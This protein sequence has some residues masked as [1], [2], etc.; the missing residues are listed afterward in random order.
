MYIMVKKNKKYLKVRDV[1]TVVLFLFK[2]KEIKMKLE[3]KILKGDSQIWHRLRPNNVN[4][5]C[6]A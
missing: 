5:S 6:C 3:K 4:I 2:I 1:A